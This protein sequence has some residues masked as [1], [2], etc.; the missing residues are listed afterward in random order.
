[1]KEHAGEW[2]DGCKKA[3]S[4]WKATLPTGGPGGPGGH[5][6][7]D[8][9]PGH[10]N[11]PPIP[12]EVIEAC[13]EDK[14]KLC[15]N[16]KGEEAMKC[17]KEHTG[18]WS[19][20]CKKA[21]SDWRASHPT[22]HPH[23]SIPA[24]VIDACAADKL[25][26]CA[27]LE[28]REGMKC[29]R[30]HYDE[31]SD[32]CTKAVNDWWTSMHSGK[33][34][35]SDSPGTNIPGTDGSTSFP[36]TIV[37]PSDVITVQPPSVE[38]PIALIDSPMATTSIPLCQSYSAS[39]ASVSAE[40]M[41]VVNMAYSP[42]QSASFMVGGE[43]RHHPHV[44]VYVGATIGGVLLVGLTVV[45]V[46]RYRSRLSA[47]QQTSTPAPEAATV[48]RNPLAYNNLSEAPDSSASNSLP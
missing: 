22:N 26:F 1:M 33:P 34:K 4:D 11:H 25:K 6:P 20:G 29:M 46:K 21:V 19:D 10:P 48:N 5:G 43:P 28:G 47:L 9:G 15:P 23:P 18:E 42:E 27:N 8:H 40:A 35:T 16:A 39:G 30:E 2:S 32:V 37:Q 45:A 38:A 13:K 7:G 3:V 31:F 12:H 36:G 44:G 24:S 41:S 17:M 14:E